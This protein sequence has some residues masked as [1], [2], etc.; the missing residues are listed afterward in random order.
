M[1]RKRTIVVFLIL[2][3]SVLGLALWAEANPTPSAFAQAGGP[4][5]SMLSVTA[6]AEGN[7]FDALWLLDLSSDKLYAFYPPMP[8]GR[9]IQPLAP[10]DLRSDFA[11]QTP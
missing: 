10:R 8:A 9:E 2:L 1:N 5:G 4:R 11:G 7:S 6:K 3:N